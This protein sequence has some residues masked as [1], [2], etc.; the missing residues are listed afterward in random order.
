MT[1]K[2]AAII[3]FAWPNYNRIPRYESKRVASSFDE[4]LRVVQLAA[5]S[6]LIDKCSHVPGI[7]YSD[8]SR[9][10]STQSVISFLSAGMAA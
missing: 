8:P 7:E 6:N 10:S 1:A 4:C 9:D 5:L 3:R 2:N